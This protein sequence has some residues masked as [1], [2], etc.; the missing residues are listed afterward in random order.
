[1]SQTNSYPEGSVTEAHIQELKP[2][3]LDPTLDLVIVTLSYKRSTFR[4]STAINDATQ[5]VTNLLDVTDAIAALEHK[6]REAE[7]VGERLRVL[8]EE[9]EDRKRSLEYGLDRLNELV[10]TKVRRRTEKLWRRCNKA[11]AELAEARR[12]A[13]G[14]YAFMTGG[15]GG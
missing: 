6:R 7:Q 1:M 8:T 9:T 13:R 4:K 5:A 10:E 2:H 12:N 15:E 14:F 11:R 3:P